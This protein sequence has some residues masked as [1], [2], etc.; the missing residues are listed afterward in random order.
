MASGVLEAIRN[1]SLKTEVVIPDGGTGHRA[2]IPRPS[3]SGAHDFLTSRLRA[4]TKWADGRSRRR[5]EALREAN[6]R[7][8]RGGGAHAEPMP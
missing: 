5:E 7:L 8:M 4:P 1:L 2:A 6:V 3:V